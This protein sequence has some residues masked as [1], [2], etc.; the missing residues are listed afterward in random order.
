MVAQVLADPAS[1]FFPDALVYVADLTK[2]EKHLLLFTQLLDL[3][4]P[5]ILVLNM[6]DAAEELGVKVNTAPPN[7]SACR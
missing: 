6:A 7:A 5:M 3:N 2:L 1:E 4:L